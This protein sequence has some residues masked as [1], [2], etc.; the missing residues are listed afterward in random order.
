MLCHLVAHSADTL[1]C[2]LV[3]LV[4]LLILRRPADNEDAA[5]ATIKSKQNLRH[6][7][8]RIE[9]AMPARSLASAM[10]RTLWCSRFLVASRHGL[11][12][13]CPIPDDP[14]LLDFRPVEAHSFKH[15]RLRI[16]QASVAER[17]AALPPGR[18]HL[19]F[20]TQVAFGSFPACRRSMTRA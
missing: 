16:D 14:K 17:R 20:S 8:H 4:S 18:E 9:Q 10:A 12:R 13:F 3:V 19:H 5:V 2:T 6:P 15:H 1:R 11:S 7:F